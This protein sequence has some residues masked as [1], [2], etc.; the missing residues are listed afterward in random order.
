MKKRFIRWLLPIVA[1]VAIAMI[2]TLN[3]PLI[4]AHAAPTTDHQIV[5]PAAGV[6]PDSFW[7][8]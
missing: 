1:I 6:T 5:S 4:M 3:V 8:G 2:A 7:H